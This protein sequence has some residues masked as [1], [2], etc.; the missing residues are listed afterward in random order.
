MTNA[1]L[2]TYTGLQKSNYPVERRKSSRR[3]AGRLA[4][5]D[6]EHGTVESQRLPR[7]HIPGKGL[8]TAGPAEKRVLKRVASRRARRTGRDESTKGYLV[9]F[10]EILPED[11]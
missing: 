10:D 11:E 2:E 9:Y 8:V 3:H 7:L 4:H 1:E 6:P 5:R